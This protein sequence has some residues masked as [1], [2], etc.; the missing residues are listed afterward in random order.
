MEKFLPVICSSRLFKGISPYK[1]LELLQ[2]LDAKQVSFKKDEY[3]FHAGDS[4]SSLGLILSGSILVIR[5][6]FWGNRNIINSLGLSQCFAETFA[7]A[8]N[9]MMEVSVT[10]AS[11]CQILFLNVQNIL[12]DSSSG[13]EDMNLLIK[14]LLSDLAQKN[15]AFTEKLSHLGQRTTRA[16]LIS[17]LSAESRKHHSVSFDIPFTRQQLADYLFVDRSGLSSELG[18]MQKEGLIDFHKNHFILKS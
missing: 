18:K 6:D 10:A 16:K 9:S 13:C 14:N 4:T 2:V 8:R 5:E 1:T 7:C 15:I 12:T 3:I 11:D 17:Y